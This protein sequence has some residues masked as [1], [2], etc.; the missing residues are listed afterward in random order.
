MVNI[1]DLIIFITITKLICEK[2]PTFD[3]L[4]ILFPPKIRFK[5]MH[6]APYQNVM[7]VSKHFIS[8]WRLTC[9]PAS[10]FECTPARDALAAMHLNFQNISRVTTR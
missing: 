5:K 6:P 9:H 10:S 1:E 7:L 4:S 2:S 3:T 8:K